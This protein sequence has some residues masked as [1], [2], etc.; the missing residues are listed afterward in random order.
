MRRVK[1]MFKALIASYIITGI[2][3]LVLALVLYKVEPPEGV[4]QVG[5]IFSYIVSP[6]VGGIL[7]GKGEETKRFLWGAFLGVLYFCII[8]AVSIVLSQSLFDRFG[9]VVSVFGMCALGGM[10][11]GMIS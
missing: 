8:F 9:M 1:R 4:I 7:V 6:F 10:L 11:G 3:L 2:F 5:I